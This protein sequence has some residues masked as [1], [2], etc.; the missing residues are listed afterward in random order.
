MSSRKKSLETTE[1][2]EVSL[3]CQVS[4]PDAKVERTKGD[5]PVTTD[6]EELVLEESAN[7][8]SLEITR[9]MLKH[10]GAYS[11]SVSG[12]RNRMS[13]SLLAKGKPVKLMFQLSI[14]S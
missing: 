2:D 3:I 1:Q 7:Q 11:Y 14:N 12:G 8:R 4:R 13:E 9:S 10:A 6:G 5:K